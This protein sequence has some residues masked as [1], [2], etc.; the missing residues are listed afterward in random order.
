MTLLDRRREVTGA[1]VVVVAA[2]FVLLLSAVR[3]RVGQTAGV[4]S[5]GKR[6]AMAEM[7]LRTL[8]G[9]MWRLSEHRGEVVAVNLWATWCG[10]CREET[11]MLVRA[12]QDLRAEGFAVVGVS[13]DDG[14]RE[15]K[16]RAFRAQYGVGYPLAF[17]DAMSQMSA[18]LEGIPTTLLIDRQ[19]RVA[20]TYVGEMRER[21]LRSDVGELLGER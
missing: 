6:Q 3:G 2:L 7:S 12:A 17:P 8:E 5:V 15:A 19:G 10:P 11:P 18:G 13:L 1:L 20:K 9:G 4:E 14:D 16:V 21:V